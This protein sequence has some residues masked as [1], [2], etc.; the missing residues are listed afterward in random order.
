MREQR[1]QLWTIDGKDAFL[2]LPQKS[3]VYVNPPRGYEHLLEEDEVWVLE[4]LLP[5]QRAGTREWGLFLK[6]T[7]EEEQYESL[8]LSPN[9]FAKRSASGQVEGAILVHVDD[10]KAK[11][12]W[13]PSLY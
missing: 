2:Q 9:L 4:K 7:L 13:N 11:L 5:G 3:K 6:D 10:I 12:S 8:A 1:F